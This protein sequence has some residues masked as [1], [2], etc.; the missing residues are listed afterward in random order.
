M[1][2]STVKM[3]FYPLLSAARF[4]MSCPSL[5]VLKSF[6]LLLYTQIHANLFGQKVKSKVLYI[7]K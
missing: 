1:S 3:N 7:S 2:L 4:I 6:N 5:R